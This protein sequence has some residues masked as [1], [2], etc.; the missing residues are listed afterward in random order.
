VLDLVSLLPHLILDVAALHVE[1]TLLLLLHLEVDLLA[2]GLL[3]LLLPLNGVT[4]RLLLHVAL[5]RHQD[6]ARAFL[7]LIELLP[8]LEREIRSGWPITFYSS[9]LSRAIRF[10]RS[11]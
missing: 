11:L 3:L 2:E 6:V 10:E 8:R 7:G 4:L 9:C 1:G 5:S